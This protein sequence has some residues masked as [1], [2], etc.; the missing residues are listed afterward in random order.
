MVD[1]TYTYKGLVRY[2]GLM[3]AIITDDEGHPFAITSYVIGN[4]LKKGFSDLDLGPVNRDN[5]P[6]FQAFSDALRSMIFF[7][8]DIP[9]GL[10]QF[11]GAK[12]ID[13]LQ[14]IE[15][16]GQQKFAHG[17]R[18]S[19]SEDDRRRLLS[20]VTQTQPVPENFVAISDGLALGVAQKPLPVSTDGA[21]LYLDDKNARSGGVREVFSEE[22]T[23]FGCFNVSPKLTGLPNCHKAL[24]A[25]RFV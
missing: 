22:A 3:Y 23:T 15:D 19:L 8:N 25:F 16:L 10:S 2:N 13:A 17:A 21:I 1:Q 14:H 12:K 9:E 6:S 24:A 20:R 18:K 4:L 11:H 5:H 7:I